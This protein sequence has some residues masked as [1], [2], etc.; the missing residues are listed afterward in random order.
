[1]IYSTSGTLG[2]TLITAIKLKDIADREGNVYV[3]HYTVHTDLQEQIREI[4]SL[5]PIIPNFVKERDVVHKRITSDFSDIQTFSDFSPFPHFDFG[6]TSRMNG[7]DYCVVV[8]R[9]GRKDQDRFYWPALQFPLH[10]S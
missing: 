8:P 3:N 5:T 9:S 7:D 4:Y 10:G 6:D 2:D 1:M